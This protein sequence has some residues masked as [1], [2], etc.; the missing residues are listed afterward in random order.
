[1]TKICDIPYPICDLTKNSKPYLWLVLV[2]RYN[3]S[4]GQT[5]VKL[6]LT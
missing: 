5:N 6:L 1:M 3:S 4:L 2:M